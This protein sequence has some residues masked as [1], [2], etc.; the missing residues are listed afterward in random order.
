LYLEAFQKFTRDAG[1]FQAHECFF[2]TAVAQQIDA[3]IPDNPP[4]E[5]RK[6]LVDGG[7]IKA[8]TQECQYKFRE[9]LFERSMFQLVFFC[10]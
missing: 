7:N 6:F 10:K 8:N 3:A 9:M 5:N 4:V 1:A 2:G